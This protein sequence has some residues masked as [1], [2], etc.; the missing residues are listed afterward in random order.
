MSILRFLDNNDAEINIRQ[1]QLALDH[2]ESFSRSISR[3][4]SVKDKADNTTPANQ[5]VQLIEDENI[6]V[7]KVSINLHSVHLK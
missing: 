7:G 4:D 3:Q 1:N 2:L 6:E 5:G